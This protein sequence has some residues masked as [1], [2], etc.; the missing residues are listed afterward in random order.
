M[1]TRFGKALAYD[2]GSPH[3][4]SQDSLIVCSLM[5]NSKHY[6][7]DFDSPM[8]TK[9]DRE[10]AY[11]KESSLKKNIILSKMFLLFIYFSPPWQRTFNAAKG[12]YKVSCLDQSVM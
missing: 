5:T 1:T 8:D 9:F 3:T 4:R 11:D 6:I 10:V 12:C 7:F 2:T